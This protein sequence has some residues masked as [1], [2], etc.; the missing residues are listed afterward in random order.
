VEPAFVVRRTPTP[1]LHPPPTGLITWVS[2]QATLAPV[3]KL[4]DG[5]AFSIVCD[6]LGTPVRL[7]DEAG[8]TAWAGEVSSW[9]ILTL[10]TGDAV[11]CPFRF[12]GQYEDQETGLYYNRHRYYDPRAG[13]Y[14]NTDPIRLNGGLNL[15]A[16]VGDPLTEIDLL[17]LIVDYEATMRQIQEDLD[18]SSAPDGAVFWSGTPRGRTAR[19]WAEKQG[20]TT[21]E[22]TAGGRYL[23]GLTLFDE[24]ESGLSSQQ[25]GELWD[26]ASGRFAE[27]ASG[28]VN[29]F[30]TGTK[31]ASLYGERTWWRIEKP[32]LAM[33][34][35][36]TAIIRRRIDGD[37]CK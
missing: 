20:K 31:K 25:A 3:A 13:Q 16:Y 30:S 23:D 10:T 26:A 22:Q 4:V 29:V 14:L 2:D 27:G 32:I 17:G 19:D 9:G 12:L 37:V 21:I 5:R 11:D 6:H 18:F 36:V 28:E 33:N 24:G 8:R 34:P 7:L 35:K 15:F 1:Q